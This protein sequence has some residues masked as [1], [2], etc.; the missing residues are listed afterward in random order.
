MKD[1]ETTR[2]IFRAWLG[3]ERHDDLS[4]VI[5]IFPDIPAKNDAYSCL[6]YEHVGQH[7]PCDPTVC[8]HPR[9]RPARP[10]EYADL[11]K[12]LEA[13]GYKLEVRMKMPPSAASIRAA[14][15]GR[16]KGTTK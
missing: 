11:K 6:S 16:M 13:I 2:V 4:D 15:L 8:R 1:G 9:T 10:E 5:A 14:E 12:E 7:G 3:K